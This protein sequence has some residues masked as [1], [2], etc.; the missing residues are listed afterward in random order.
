[1]HS[2]LITLSPRLLGALSEHPGLSESIPFQ[3][4][5]LMVVF[6]ALGLIWLVLTVVGQFFKRTAP[7][8]VVPAPAVTAPVPVSAPDSLPPELIAVIAATVRVSLEGPYR[9]Q[10]IVPVPAGQD[11]AHEGRRQIFASHQVR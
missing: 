8:P 3:L 7:A 11:W 9:I 4:T 1:M 10:A 6:T 5:G 2:L